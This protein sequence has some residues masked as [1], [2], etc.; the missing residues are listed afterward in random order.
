MHSILASTLRPT[1]LQGRPQNPMNGSDS[2]SFAM[3]KIV[4]ACRGEGHWGSREE[5]NSK[6]DMVFSAPHPWH[7][8]ERLIVLSQ[9][10][11]GPTY[12]TTLSQGFKLTG[13]AKSAAIRTNHGVCVAWVNRDANRIYW[14]YVHP[15]STTRPQ[16][17]GAYH[18]VTPAMLYDLA[19][20]A[21]LKRSGNTGG[22]GIIVRKRS[23]HFDFIRKR[24]KSIYR[25]FGTLFS[26]ALG[27]VEL[28]RLGWRH[29]FR[30]G[31]RLENKSTSLDIIPYLKRILE[32]WPSSHAITSH[33]TFT[34][35][36]FTHRICE[37]LMKFN[38][39]KIQESSTSAPTG[40][41]GY[42]R[43][44]EEIRYPANWES[45]VMLS[46]LVTRRI[47]LRSAYFKM[48]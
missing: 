21:G 25:S 19:R 29:M 7:K 40:A 18:E 20:C 38:D 44:V 27:K 37:H 28:T 26:P 41:V 46:Q 48:A 5:D 31:R 30:A 15:T 45:N 1:A 34:S 23:Q 11:S 14:A 4:L 24:V 43:V 13:A 3:A 10:K 6:I 22:K 17:Y 8:R 47:V 33:K 16:E 9:V 12:G 39:I 35:K 36:G 42:I 32:Q 2:E